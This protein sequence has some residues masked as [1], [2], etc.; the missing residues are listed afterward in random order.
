MATTL[1]PA[2]PKYQFRFLALAR[3]DLSAKPCRLSVEATSEREARLILAP[4]Y[5]LSFA[6]RLPVPEAHHA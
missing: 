3:A 2:C 1:I 4:H 6:G 5:I